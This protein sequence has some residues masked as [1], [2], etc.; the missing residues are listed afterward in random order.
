MLENKE[1]HVL[2]S[3]ILTAHGKIDISQCLGNSSYNLFLMMNESEKLSETGPLT[4]QVKTVNGP[5]PD[6]FCCVSCPSINP[7]LLSRFQ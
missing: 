2:C 6:S 4:V 7:S 5:S 3:I 1:S